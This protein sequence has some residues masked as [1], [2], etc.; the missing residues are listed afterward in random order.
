MPPDNVPLIEPLAVAHHAFKLADIPTDDGVRRTV[1]ILGGGPI[2]QALIYV[3][4]AHRD[5]LNIVLS[6]PFQVRRDT[7]N[8]ADRTLN[9]TADDVTAYCCQSSR[10]SAGADVVFDCAGIQPAAETG[11]AALRYRGVYVTVA[12]WE[13][14]VRS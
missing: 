11:F 2:G 14:T 7:A 1:L 10:D 4:R 12:L 5:N 9:P 13:H 3:L 8:R 6:D